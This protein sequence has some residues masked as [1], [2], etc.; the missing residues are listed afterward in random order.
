LVSAKNMLGAGLARIW[1]GLDLGSLAQGAGR[2][3]HSACTRIEIFG[4][5]DIFFVPSTNPKCP[6]KGVNWTLQEKLT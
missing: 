6:D 1:A 2:Y 3:R 5:G 4:K